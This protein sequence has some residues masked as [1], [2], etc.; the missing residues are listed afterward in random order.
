MFWLRELIPELQLLLPTSRKQ[1][2]S[3]SMGT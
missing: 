3:F 2:C 1:L